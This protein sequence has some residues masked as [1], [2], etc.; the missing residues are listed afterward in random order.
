VMIA[1]HDDSDSDGDILTVSSEKSYNE[2]YGG[3]A[4]LC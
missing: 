3:L 4:H 2:K 1:K